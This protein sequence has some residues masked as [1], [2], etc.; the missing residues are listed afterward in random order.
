MK[1]KKKKIYLGNIKER[2]AELFLWKKI[3]FE[4]RVNLARN[5]A[6]EIKKIHKKLGIKS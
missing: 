6:E 1:N 2:E 5:F 4:K 3:P